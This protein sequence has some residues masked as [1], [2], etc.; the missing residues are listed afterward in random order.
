MINKALTISRQNAERD[1]GQ[2]KWET[3][4]EGRFTNSTQYSALKSDFS[5]TIH[6]IT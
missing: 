6:W 4:K 1:I 3:I 2:G 5:N